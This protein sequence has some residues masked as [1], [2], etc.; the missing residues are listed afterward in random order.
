[1]AHGCG[2]PPRWL[3]GGEKL[4]GRFVSRWLEGC[5]LMVGRRGGIGED[6]VKDGQEG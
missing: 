1:M 4:L 3:G 5:K 6:G 2:R